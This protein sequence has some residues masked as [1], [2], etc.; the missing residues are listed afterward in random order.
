[1]T[2]LMELRQK[3]AEAIET[4]RG[5][6]EGAEAEDRAMSDE[7]QAS[8]DELKAQ[9]EALKARI[10]RMEE[11]EDLSEEAQRSLP[12]KAP[13][14]NK[15]RP[16][17]TESRAVAHYIRTGDANQLQEFRAPNATD[18]NI[19]TPA[20]GGYAVPTGHYNQIVARRDEDMLATALGVTKITGKGTTVNVPVD[21]EA[22]GEFVATTE[23]TQFTLDSPAIN[24]VA[25][26]L[27]AYSKRIPISYQLLE[28]EDSNLLQFVADWVGRGMARTHNNLLLT[29]AR[30]SGTAA[31]TLDSASTIGATEVP[32]LVYKLPDPYQKSGSSVAWVMKRAT[33]GIIRGLQGSSFLFVPNPSGTDRGMPEIWGYPVYSSEY[34]SAIAASAKS[35]IFGDW[36]YVYMRE[37]T[38]FGFLRD[39]YTLADYGQIRLMYFFRTVY[40]VAQAEAIVYATHPTA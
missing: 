32:E 9:V 18:M 8:Y 17:D 25:M 1:M 10:E 21:N 12:R 13:A 35:L 34:A 29:E 3:R 27:V 39:P 5:L 4:M 7:E 36:S 38:Q 33:E 15:T 23:A 11:A 30:A 19:G 14:F 28:D 2:K 16:G 24:Q 6:V 22:D 40:K 20:D 37:S 26:T 31:L